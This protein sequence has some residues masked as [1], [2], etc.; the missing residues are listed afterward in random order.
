[1][2]I[3]DY[4]T[5]CK[6]YKA[7]LIQWRQPQ[8]W[9]E[10]SPEK[11]K[12]LALYICQKKQQRLV[13]PLTKVYINV[14]LKSFCLRENT[15]DHKMIGL[16][17]ELDIVDVRINAALFDVSIKHIHVSFSQISTTR[18]FVPRAIDGF[19]FELVFYY[20]FIY[21]IGTI[22]QFK[23]F[24]TQTTFSVQTDCTRLGS[25]LCLHSTSCLRLS[26]YFIIQW[27][28]VAA[29]FRGRSIWCLSIS[30]ERSC[31]SVS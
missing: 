2:N 25:V 26:P 1:M 13:V 29:Y 23:L 17:T 21:D 4:S 5:H 31:V 11:P 14:C 15:L 6:I 20:Y 18:S 24:L 30:V 12:L 10:N 28:P 7:L 16:R 3:L 8:V 27:K 19:G 22:D 9:P